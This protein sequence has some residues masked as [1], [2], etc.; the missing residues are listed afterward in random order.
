MKIYPFNLFYI[1]RS[2]GR[3]GAT[4]FWEDCN[5]RNQLTINKTNKRNK[6]LSIDYV[7]ALSYS[8]T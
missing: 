2:N 7:T 8:E 4:A 1:T 5:Q 3:L 6:H